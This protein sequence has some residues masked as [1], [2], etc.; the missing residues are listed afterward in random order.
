[1]THR[2]AF[3][4]GKFPE[5]T[6]MMRSMKRLLVIL[7]AMAIAATPHAITPLRADPPPTQGVRISPIGKPIWKPVDFHL[8]AAPIGTASD[9]Y[10]ESMTTALALLPP[11]NHVFIPSL[12]VG[13]GAP[14]R[15]PYDSELA[16]GVDDLGFHEGDRFRISEFSGA[17][18]VWLVW[19]NVPMPGTMGSSPDSKFHARII[20]NS[21]FPIHVEGVSYHNNKVFDPFLLGPFDVPPLDENVD[22]RFAGLDGHSHFPIFNADNASFGP[23]GEKLNGSYVYKYTMMDQ[24][25]NG[26]AIEA[27]FTVTP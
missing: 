22:P 27:H 26:W 11:P 16:D 13:P 24:S 9:N 20:P 1:M 5:E 17:N 23:P 3:S 7:S 4:D 19:M 12:L 15:P 21:L 14:H 18:G 25:G 6:D 2:F 8:F 10:A